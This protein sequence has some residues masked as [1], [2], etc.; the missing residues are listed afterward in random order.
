MKDRVLVP[1]LADRGAHFG[2]HYLFENRWN[3]RRSVPRRQTLDLVC[4]VSIVR[5]EEFT[6]HR[7]HI[8]LVL[9]GAPVQEVNLLVQVLVPCDV[10]RLEVLSRRGFPD[11]LLDA[12]SGDVIRGSFAKPPPKGSTD[13]QI[14][15]HR[16][17]GRFVTD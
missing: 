2:L 10:A 12:R 4:R 16:Y 11:Q 7:A 15:P 9:H 13:F 1:N 17:L 6:I 3:G 5:S 14:L 8:S